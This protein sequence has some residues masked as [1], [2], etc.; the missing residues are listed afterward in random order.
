[1]KIHFL[2]TNGWY[3]TT[4]AGNTICTLLE[5]KDAYIV[6]DLGF[7]VQKLD[8][9]I[10]D[11]RPIYIFISHFHLDHVCGFHVLP[12]FKF[13]QG[14]NIIYQDNI[15]NRAT[16]KSLSH[17]PL[18]A[19]FD[20]YG[21]PI[22]LFPI[23]S[24]GHTKPLEFEC[25]SLKHAA[26]CFGYRLYVEDKV[27]TYCCDTAPCKNDLRLAQNAD[28]LIHESSMSPGTSDWKWGHSNPSEAA[29]IAK[30]SKAKKLILTHFGP[31]EYNTVAKKRAVKKIVKNI[32]SNTVVGIDDT[33]IQI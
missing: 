21:Y 30:D 20:F 15:A 13:K 25:L 29:L 31:G 6:F 28:V 8:K 27:V 11:D 9:Y 7:G 4:S 17:P 16:L 32:F 14:V 24:G 19:T 10:K 33:T 1:M 18:C 2:G 5:T 23:K 26:A 3:D 22:K 12:K